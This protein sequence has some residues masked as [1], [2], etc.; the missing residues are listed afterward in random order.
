MT[1][2]RRSHGAVA[3][4]GLFGGGNLGNEATLGAVLGEIRR[5]APGVRCV[6]VSDPPGVEAALDGFDR[7]LPHDLLPVPRGWWAWLP[8]RLQ[9]PVRIALHWITEPLRYRRTRRRY[10]ARHAHGAGT[11]IAD[12]YG[13]GPLD[14]PHHM[15]RWCGV[16]QSDG[17]LRCFPSIG[18]GPASHPCAPL[19]F[20]RRSQVPDT[21][22]IERVFLAFAR[23]W[24]RRARPGAA[25]PG[26]QPAGRSRARRPRQWPPRSIG[27]GVMG[28]SGWN[29]EGCRPPKNYS[30]YLNKIEWLAPGCCKTDIGFACSSAIGAVTAGRCRTE[31]ARYCRITGP[32]RAP[33]GVRHQHPT[34]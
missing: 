12:D 9:S 27:L 1:G 34:T 26:I 3:L 25:R 19:V 11:G 16:A 6:L 23:D 28:Y 7:C 30:R 33:G 24:R 20:G 29:V 4:F 10:A 18:A 2:T 31:R 17:R 5:R 22:H 14:A 8:S 15:A 32:G 13:Q 21:A